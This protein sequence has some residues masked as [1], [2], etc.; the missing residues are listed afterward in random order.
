MWHSVIPNCS[1][2]NNLCWKA[3]F[4]LVLF[5]AGLLG[6]RMDNIHGRDLH[7]RCRD[8]RMVN[9][10][11]RCSPSPGARWCKEKQ[12]GLSSLKR[13]RSRL[14]L[15]LINLK[16]SC[17]YG[18][19]S[20]QRHHPLLELEQMGLIWIKQP[21]CPERTDKQSFFFLFLGTHDRGHFSWL[22]M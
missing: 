4:L 19:T 9:A 12:D 16:L 8:Q 5:L 2:F 21:K 11:D 7:R 22:F 6:L 1:L 20:Y 10:G 14:C 18:M 3:F 17:W 13:G 15:L